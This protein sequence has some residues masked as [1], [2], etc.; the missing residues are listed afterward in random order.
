M[1]ALSGEHDTDQA[2]AIAFKSWD[3]HTAGTDKLRAK[4]AEKFPKEKFELLRD[5][6]VFCEHETT[7]AAGE[8]QVYDREALA[9]ICDKMNHRIADVGAYAKISRGHTP[10]PEDVAN[11]AE[12]PEVLGFQGPYRLG[13]IGNEN[14]KYAIFAD[15]FWFRDKAGER[16]KLPGRSVEIWQH[17]EMA[18]RFFDPVA[19]LGAETPRLDMPM[20][21]ARAANGVEIAK[22]SGAVY[23]GGSNSYV[24]N[25]A[26]TA[27]KPPKKERYEMFSPEDLDKL[28][29]LVAEKLKGDTTGEEADDYALDVPTE[30]GADEIEGKDKF[31]MPEDADKEDYRYD[32]EGKGL[33]GDEDEEEVSAKKMSRVR[34][35]VAALRS[36]LALE[37]AKYAR[38]AETVES[39]RRDKINA[40]RYAR[41]TD[42]QSQGYVF[43]PSTKTVGG[44]D[45]RVP[46]IDREMERC[47]KMNDPAFADHLVV[48]AE[49][50][51][52]QERAQAMLYV[53]TGSIEPSDDS[54]S[55][56]AVS[57]EA[58][59]RTEK[60]RKDG[61]K[62][63]YADVLAE[64]RKERGMKTA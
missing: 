55:R 48:I 9:A 64:V 5:V 60:Y 26:D 25:P 58:R 10:D 28:A 21:F 46:G 4:A 37:K 1:A 39:L 22:Y 29:T 33:A 8:P 45:V 50:Y 14:P 16:A 53:P 44:K 6:P 57:L 15:E 63:D 42:L 40:E 35:E 19:A 20:K 23:P 12:Q 43:R 61:K 31:E 52:R 49:N 59:K 38:H 27:T 30:T 11:G 62:I 13:M 41:L 3:K 34:S 7:N 32:L 54:D 24:P 36:E 18:E 17:P 51:E 56:E 2:N 47:S